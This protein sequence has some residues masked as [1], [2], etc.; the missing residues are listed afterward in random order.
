MM[1]GGGALDQLVTECAEGGVSLLGPEELGCHE[2]LLKDREEASVT[3][4]EV[5]KV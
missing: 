3:W 5:A 2:G 4:Q 1:E